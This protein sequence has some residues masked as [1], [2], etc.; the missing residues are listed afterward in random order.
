MGQRRD[1]LCA[2]C[3]KTAEEWV[4]GARGEVDLLPIS[5]KGFGE[6]VSSQEEPGQPGIVISAHRLNRYV[7]ETF[8]CPKQNNH[9][10]SFFFFLLKKKADVGAR[11]TDLTQVF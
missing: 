8:F 9:C 10:F 2:Q 3:T 4:Q 5:K 6:E 1:R 7:K 11:Q